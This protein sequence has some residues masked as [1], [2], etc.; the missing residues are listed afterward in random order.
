MN[1]RTVMIPEADIEIARG[2]LLRSIATDQA[3]V[4]RLNMLATAY[5]DHARG[6]DASNQLDR[7]RRKQAVAQALLDQL[8]DA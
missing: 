7:V 4:V 1:N 2:L 6:Q 5:G 8:G 3:D